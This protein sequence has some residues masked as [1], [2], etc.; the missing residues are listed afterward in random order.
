MT[1]EIHHPAFPQPEDLDINLWRY[2]DLFKFQWLL[3]NS[4]LYFPGVNELG[5]DV[6]EGTQPIGDKAW[7][8]E[9]ID[10]EQDSDKKLILE[11]NSKIITEFSKKFREYYF[12]L[13]WHMNSSESEEMWKH[14]TSS[15]ESLVIKTKYSNLRSL[16]PSVVYMGKVRYIDY[17]S[18][19]IPSLNVLE[20]IIH[21]DLPYEFESEVRA[22]AAPLTKIDLE[23]KEF[24]GNLFTK[25]DD[26]NVMIY[27][28]TV[29]IV[30]LIEE[31]ILH[32]EA[33]A[34]FT[35]GIK[36]MC[37]KNGLPQPTRSVLEVA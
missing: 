6:L 27:A 23:R 16:L 26:Q 30:D 12:V 2:M 18:E 5:P 31:V 19:K 37:L 15:S 20:F 21:K 10:E 36:D 34:E 22:V 3:E 14:Y 24:E 35:D 28:P 33:S 9:K 11:N 29:S 8:Q 4:R 13:C 25:K 17:M 1:R 7:W 32:P